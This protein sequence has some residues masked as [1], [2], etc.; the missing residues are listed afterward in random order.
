MN[1]LC[2]SFS[3]SLNLN[4]LRKELKDSRKHDIPNWVATGIPLMFVKGP[5]SI[6]FKLVLQAWFENFNVTSYTG[7][8]PIN[9]Q[10]LLSSAIII[11]IIFKVS[12][13]NYIMI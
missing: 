13:L 11:I 6:Q 5:F 7:T 2:T 12:L 9:C 10:P 4:E 1:L 8:H 3:P